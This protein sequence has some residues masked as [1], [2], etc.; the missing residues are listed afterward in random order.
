MEKT[1]EPA[2]NEFV[3]CWIKRKVVLHRLGISPNTLK[4]MIARGE[5]HLIVLGPNCHRFSENEIANLMAKKIGEY[6]AQ[7]A[8]ISG[9]E[10]DQNEQMDM[11]FG[12]DWQAEIPKYR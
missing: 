2:A 9:A 10:Q 6:A 5:I 1:V 3:D 8:E 4:K 12:C 11:L 7:V